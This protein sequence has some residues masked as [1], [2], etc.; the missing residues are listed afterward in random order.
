MSL[1]ETSRREFLKFLGGIAGGIVSGTPVLSFLTRTE[2]RNNFSNNKFSIGGEKEK[3][4]TESEVGVMNIGEESVSTAIEPSVIDESRVTEINKPD[5]VKNGLQLLEKLEL[6]GKIVYLVYGRPAGGWGSLGESTTAEQSWELAKKRK[7]TISQE[8]EKSENDFAYTI[9]NPVYFSDNRS[10]GAIKDIYVS[11]GLELASKNK[12]L[13]SLDFSDIQ[14]AKEVI[15]GFEGK[16]PPQKLA[17]LAVSFDV[18]HFLPSGSLEAVK[19]N[20]FSQ[21]FAEK[22]QK[23]ANEVNMNIPGFVFV[24]TFGGGRILNLNQLQQYYLSSNTLVIPIFDGYGSDGQKLFSMARYV[25]ALPN[26]QEF[27]ALVGVMEFHTKHGRRYD[28]VSPKSTF[29]TL[30]GAPVFFFASQ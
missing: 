29:K 2:V 10:S 15:S 3:I 25:E 20:E 5:E 28:T 6:K 1:P 11:K 17:Y 23:W 13:V 19:I 24:Y 7:R 27:P 4:L 18:E 12:G 16:F 30:E 21:W 26:T 22:H 9:I 8:I 14:K